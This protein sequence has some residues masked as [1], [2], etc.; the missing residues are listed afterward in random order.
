MAVIVNRAIDE[1]LPSDGQYNIIAEPGRY[2]VTSAFILCPN[3]IGKKE[4]K[5]NEGLEAMY[6]IN[7]GIYGL[8]THNLFHDYKP[9][10]V[11]KEFLFNELS[12]NW[13]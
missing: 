6:I 7:E 10:P 4:R 5:T 2:V 11:F 3:I 9:K 1:Y 13:F 8:F 12:S